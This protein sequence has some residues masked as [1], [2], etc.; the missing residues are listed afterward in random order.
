MYVVIYVNDKLFKCG[1]CL[2]IF[3]G[4]IMLNN[5]ICIYIG[6]WLFFC[7]KCGKFFI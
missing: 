2:C 7:E 6:E 1:Y 4:V 5:Y 3:V